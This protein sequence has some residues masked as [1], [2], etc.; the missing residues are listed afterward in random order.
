VNLTLMRHE[1]R[2]YL[3]AETRPALLF[4]N[5]NLGHFMWNDLSGLHHV[6]A[7]GWLPRVAQLVALPRQFIDAR[8]VFPELTDLPYTEL[9]SGADAF[10]Y[11]LR[12]RLLPV[13]AA[14]PVVTDAFSERLREY[15]DRRGSI[16]AAVRDR[17]GPLIWMNLRAHSKVWTDQVEGNAALLNAAQEAYGDI[18]VVLDGMNDCAD[19][20]AQ[21]RAR[22]DPNVTVYDGIGVPLADTLKWAFEVDCFACPVGTGMAMVTW[23]GK[24]HGVA[25]A[26]HEHM[27]HLAWWPDV[28]EG[29]P[30]PLSPS[31][32]QITDVGGGF[33]C[34]YEVDWRVLWPLLTQ[35]LDSLGY[36]R[37]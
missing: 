13:R 33:Y 36:K 21:I 15:A 29:A 4:G 10:A 28:R 35:V 18:S 19:I 23:W 11:C 25:H 12:N 30:A 31:L 22:L 26:E 27:T 6:I 14:S 17:R 20:A 7:S 9:A 2:E 5:S 32:D 24:K 16:P 34:N 3:D 37:T 1:A 8:Q